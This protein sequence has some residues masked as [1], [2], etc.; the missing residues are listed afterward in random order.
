[1]GKERSTKKERHNPLHVQLAEDETVKR[2]HPRAKFV[3]R[4]QQKNKEDEFVDPNLSRKILQIAR[5]QQEELEVETGTHKEQMTYDQNALFSSLMND[6]SDQDDVSEDSDDYDHEELEIDETDQE[7]LDKF[8]P[9][10]PKARKTLADIIMEK[11]ESQNMNKSASE[12]LKISFFFMAFD[13][14][15][16]LFLKKNCYVDAEEKLRSLSINPKVVEVYSKYVSPWEGYIVSVE[17]L[18]SRYPLDLLELGH[19]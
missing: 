19:Y 7:I 17:L 1:M 2:K 6:E 15:Q 13:S 12:G 10:A 16:R 14:F 8:L 3:T 18:A 11:I 9:S 5:E 4:N